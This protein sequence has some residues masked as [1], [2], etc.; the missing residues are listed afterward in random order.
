MRMCI[1]VYVVCCTRL[2][3]GLFIHIVPMIVNNRYIP[4]LANI[5]G[6]VA[7]TPGDW[8]ICFYFS[9]PVCLISEILK[10]IGRI[11][12]SRNQMEDKRQ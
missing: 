7:L 2:S 1:C 5:F 8:L 9:A 6:I 12:N 10:L 11:R 4:A 3:R